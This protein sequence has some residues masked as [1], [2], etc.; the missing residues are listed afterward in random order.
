[1]LLLINRYWSLVLISYYIRIKLFLQKYYQLFLDLLSPA[2][3]F[4]IVKNDKGKL[5]L[6]NNHDSFNHIYLA[7]QHTGSMAF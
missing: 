7:Q 5:I 3:P 2:K 4:L 1:M 6:K